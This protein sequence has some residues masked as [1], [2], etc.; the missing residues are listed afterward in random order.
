MKHEDDARLERAL[1]A[2]P[3]RDLAPPVAR[4]VLAAAEMRLAGSAKPTC[5]MRV[6]PATII[7]L[8]FTHLCWA[9]LRV[10][11]SP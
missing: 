10:Y 5:W 9:L 11:L 8:A 2:L 4:A 1:A 3:Q 7:A 6:E